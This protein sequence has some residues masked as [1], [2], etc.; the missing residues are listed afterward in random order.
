MLIIVVFVFGD[1]LPLLGASLR[2][3]KLMKALLSQRS[4]EQ[5]HMWVVK[6]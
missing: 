3:Q 4:G 5:I 2:L 6:Q 1:D